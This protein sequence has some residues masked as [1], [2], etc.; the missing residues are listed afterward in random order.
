MK[1]V[2]AKVCRK[3]EKP[4]TESSLIQCGGENSF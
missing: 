3:N 1:R 4:Q 2:W